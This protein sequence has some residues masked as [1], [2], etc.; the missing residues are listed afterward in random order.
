[1]L[2]TCCQQTKGSSLS[3]C[4]CCTADF[5]PKKKTFWWWNWPAMGTILSKETKNFRYLSWMAWESC[6]SVVEV[7][8]DRFS[9]NPREVIR[10]KIQKRFHSHHL[11]R[12]WPTLALF[13]GFQMMPHPLHRLRVHHRMVV[14]KVPG[15]PNHPVVRDDH[16]LVLNLVF[17]GSYILRN[18][19]TMVWDISESCRIQRSILLLLTIIYILIILIVWTASHG[20]QSWRCYFCSTRPC[21]YI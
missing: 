10:K 8:F 12:I 19:K 16:D 18:H 5:P 11:S 6:E 14:S 7:W 15:T 3:R 21:I 2:T 9:C 13:W 17:W 4:L 20:K 1:M